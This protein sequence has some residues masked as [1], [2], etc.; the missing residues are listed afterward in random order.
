[1]KRII[2]LV[3]CGLFLSGIAFAAPTTFGDGRQVCASSGTAVALSATDQP[4]QI[5]TI[6]A[7]TDNTGIV[8]VG[9]APIAAQATRE[10]VALYAGDCYTIREKGDLN[11]LKVDAMV[12]GDGVS[13]SWQLS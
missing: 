12:N 11:D 6:C 1:M 3:L 10:G 13:Y 7:E 9:Y 8:V 4:F 2:G 5:C